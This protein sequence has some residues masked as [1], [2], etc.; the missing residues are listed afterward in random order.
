MFR[1]KYKT[2]ICYT[3]ITL[4]ICLIPLIC[5][6]IKIIIPT[7]RDYAKQH[8]LKFYFNM[9]KTAGFCLCILAC[10]SRSL[11]AP[12]PG[13]ANVYESY[14]LKQALQKLLWPCQPHFCNMPC[15][16]V[17]FPLSVSSIFSGHTGN[18]FDTVVQP[19]K[20]KKL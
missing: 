4:Y 3:F 14:F 10:F 20:T 16:P 1:L 18:R 15:T 5:Y 13:R 17:E 2:N 8:E 11:S 19:P 9:K 12:Y 7:Y 6:L